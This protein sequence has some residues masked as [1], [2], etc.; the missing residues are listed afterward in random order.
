MTDDLTYSVFDEACPL[1]ISEAEEVLGFV[2]DNND[3]RTLSHT[4]VIESVTIMD[5]PDRERGFLIVIRLSS[6]KSIVGIAG[7]LIVRH[8]D[9]YLRS[10]KNF[11][12][13]HRNRRREGFGKKLMGMKEAYMVAHGVAEIFSCIGETNE[14]SRRM[15]ESCGYEK[16]GTFTNIRGTVLVKYRKVLKDTMHVDRRNGK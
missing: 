8:D 6:D 16:V 9:G 5:N 15:A 10:R 3:R 1:S 13:V 14:A 11:T 4:E 7:G 12:I 2:R